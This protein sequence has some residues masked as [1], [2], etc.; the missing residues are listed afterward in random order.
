MFIRGC[1][2]DGIRVSDTELL[3]EGGADFG[4]IWVAGSIF[5]DEVSFAAEFVR[6]CLEIT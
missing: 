5:F 2:E 4:L 3:I 6:R 1:Q